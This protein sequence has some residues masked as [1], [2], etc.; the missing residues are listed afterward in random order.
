[1]NTG[2]SKDVVTKAPSGLT[3]CAGEHT[4][5]RR[6]GSTNRDYILVVDDDAGLHVLLGH[7]LRPL[8]L[9]VRCALDGTTAL[10]MVA[11]HR[12][13]LIILDLRMPGLDGF[14]VLERLG[15]GQTTANIPV[16]VFSANTDLALM[17][18]YEWPTQVVKVLKKARVHPTEL[19]GLV[20]DQLGL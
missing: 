7:I 20:R 14:S 9:E 5:D 12:P 1:M 3:W 4:G 15:E 18:G 17:N 2:N 6:N 16:V 13:S 8:Q 10:D 19:R 11:A